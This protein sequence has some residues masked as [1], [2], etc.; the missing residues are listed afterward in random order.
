MSIDKK[1]QGGKKRIVLLEAIGRVHGREATA[2]A[3]QDI[4]VIL[5][6]GIKVIPSMPESL[7]VSCTPPG[8]K[9]ISNRALL[10]AVLGTGTCRM[11]NFL[12]SD[13]TKVMMTALT[14]MQAASFTWEDDSKSPTLVVTGRGG[15]LQ[16]SG[17]EL[18]LGNAGTASRFLTTAVTLAKPGSAS[19]SVLTGNKRMQQRP[20]G[21][22][23]EAL[24]KNGADISYMCDIDDQNSKVQALPLK[25]KA[26]EGIEEH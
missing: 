25:I 2:V 10:L 23:V 8:S 12:Q 21:D 5:S 6:S 22:L 17:E 13:D 19:H 11:K 3:D 1:N 15:Q 9:S 26:T 4:R 7:K 18:Y 14:Q 20:I 24:T 16:A